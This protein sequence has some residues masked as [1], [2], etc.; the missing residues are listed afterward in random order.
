MTSTDS[1]ELRILKQAFKYCRA[2]RLAIDGGANVGTFTAALLNKFRWVLA[3]EPVADTYAL[4]NARFEKRVGAILCNQALWDYTGEGL[5][6]TNPRG[7]STAY[8]ATTK[9]KHSDQ[10][11]KSVAID[12]FQGSLP[13][14]VD[15]IKLDLEGAELKALSGA[16]D[17]LANCRPVLV[18]ECVDK[19]LERY[20][21]SIAQ[22]HEWLT[23][24]DYELKHEHM[25]NRVYV[26]TIWHP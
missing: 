4:L 19:Q 3:V 18:I 5:F 10:K 12:E 16:Y 23:G 21:H 15:L 9:E 8:Y 26:P 24:A 20:G 6:M 13:A 17:T 14:P 7:K 22:M 2:H 1:E 11:V 25:V